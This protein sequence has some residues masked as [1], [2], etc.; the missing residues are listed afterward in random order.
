MRT[1]QDE[2]IHRGIDAAARWP[3]NVRD[4]YLRCDPDAIAKDVRLDD[5]FRADMLAALEA[6]R[7]LETQ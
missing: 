3:K 4:I 5:Q 7:I 1:L 6:K 2:V